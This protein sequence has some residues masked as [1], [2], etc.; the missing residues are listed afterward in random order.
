MS[1]ALN[2]AALFFGI[3]QQDATP[4][5]I[6][7]AKTEIGALMAEVVI[8]KAVTGLIAKQAEQ[9]KTEV[10]GDK[11][12]GSWLDL[13]AADCEAKLRRIT[14]GWDTNPTDTAFKRYRTDVLQSLARMHE[15]A[16]GIA[17]VTAALT[18]AF[19]LPETEEAPGD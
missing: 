17:D 16:Q 18:K 13:L 15:A 12:L 11:N 8:A 19:H 1:D 3:K 2:A 4:E 5:Q 7:K 10:E 9:I 6:Q 14:E